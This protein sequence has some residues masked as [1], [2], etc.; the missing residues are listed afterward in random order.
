[1]NLA[2]FAHLLPAFPPRGFDYD[3]FILAA[4]DLDSK[5]LKKVRDALK[6]I[7]R[8]FPRELKTVS[9]RVQYLVDNNKKPQ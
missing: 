8:D 1:M 9:Q 5:E 4:L 7:L 3:E 2:R 6:P